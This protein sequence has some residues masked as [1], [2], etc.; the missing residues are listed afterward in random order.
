MQAPPLSPLPPLKGPSTPVAPPHID[1]QRLRAIFTSSTSA[2]ELLPALLA[3]W[4]QQFHVLDAAIASTPVEANATTHIKPWLADGHHLPVE[5]L[6]LMRSAAQS[7]ISQRY[8]W[9]TVIPLLPHLRLLAIPVSDNTT[10]HTAWCFIVPEVVLNRE[11]CL[12]AELFVSL[13]ETWVH[14]NAA[15]S[16]EAIADSSSATNDHGATLLAQLLDLTAQLESAGSVD[17]AAQQLLSACAISLRYQPLAISI[18][19]GQTWWSEEPENQLDSSA[20]HLLRTVVAEA[21]LRGEPS[22]WPTWQEGNNIG[23]LLHKQ[24]QAA[25][26]YQQI[27]T[28]P[29][30]DAQLSVVAVLVLAVDPP[31]TPADTEQHTWWNLLSLRLGSTLRLLQQSGQSSLSSMASQFSSLVSWRWGWLAV[32]LL[33]I[34]STLPYPHTITCPCEVQPTVRRFI[35]APFPGIL[36]EA[37]VEPGQLVTRG[38]VLAR[39]DSR[40]NQLALAKLAAETAKVQ[41]ERDAFIG[42]RETAQA[43]ASRFE[44]ERLE[45][46]RSLLERRSH[47]LEIR[48]PIDGMVVSGELKRVAGVPLTIGQTLFE[49]APLDRMVYELRISGDDVSYVSIGQSVNTVLDAYPATT[50]TGQLAKIQPRAEKTDTS[51]AFIGQFEYPNDHALLKPGMRGHAKIDAGQ[52]SLG[53]VWFHKAYYRLRHDLGL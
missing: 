5:I 37:L 43:E 22:A 51:Y 41:V 2:T 12:A 11:W 47:D 18:I 30:N 35:T 52:K 38:Q 49:I 42:R 46:E 3:I 20:R 21:T 36:A 48:S 15:V 4:R 44:L 33:L 19:G 23:L 27:V 50:F 1:P 25:T 8:I 14:Q 40:E 45:A 32:V 7:A 6:T 17:R 31:L 24:L 10:T 28:V 39:M 9:Q 53:W 13:Y 16:T 29:L 26:N 34:A